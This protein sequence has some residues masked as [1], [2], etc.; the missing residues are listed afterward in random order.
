MGRLLVVD[1]EP[2]IRDAVA[3][4]LHDEGFEVETARDGRQALEKAAARTGLS[5]ILL[6]LMMPGMNGWQFRERQRLDPALAGIPVIIVSAGV[7]DGMD[8]DAFLPKPFRLEELIRTVR[9]VL[10]RGGPALA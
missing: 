5:A 9:A 7:T 8:A 2:D 1:D 3:E 10:A 6:D 4:A